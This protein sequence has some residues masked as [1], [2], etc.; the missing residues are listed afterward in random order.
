VI[1]RKSGDKWYVAGINGE[2]KEKQ[3]TVNLSGLASK[4]KV[5]FITDG[6]NNAEFSTQEFDVKDQKTISLKPNGGFVMVLD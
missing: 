1:A 5:K 3:I 2:N 6:N 4:G